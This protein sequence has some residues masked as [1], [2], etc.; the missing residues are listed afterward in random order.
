MTKDW[1]PMSWLKSV[2]EGLEE[3]E[4][5]NNLNDHVNL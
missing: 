5:V 2:K 1:V 4:E 3:V